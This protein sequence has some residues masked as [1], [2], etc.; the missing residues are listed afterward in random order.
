MQLTRDAAAGRVGGVQPLTRFQ[1]FVLEGFRLLNKGLDWLRQVFQSSMHM[2]NSYFWYC[3]L[4]QQTEAEVLDYTLTQ[5][6]DMMAAYCEQ[7]R[8]IPPGGLPAV[9]HCP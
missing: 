8:L 9:L 2:A 4:H 6:E 1:G 7:R 5:G 3:S